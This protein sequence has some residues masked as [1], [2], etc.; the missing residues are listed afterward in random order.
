MLIASC[1]RGVP[2]AGAP[3]PFDRDRVHADYEG[4]DFDRVIR[5]L[6]R[7]RDSGRP[8]GRADSLFMEKH[9]GVVYA[10]NPATRERGRYHF[11]RMLA[12][13]P[14]ADLL[15]M[16]VGDEVDGIFGKVR[17]EF[18]LTGASMGGP[19][20]PSRKSASHPADR[21]PYRARAKARAAAGKPADT[22]QM[23]IR[24]SAGPT[25]GLDLWSLEPVPV[26]APQPD[27]IPASRPAVAAAPLDSAARP[28]WRETGFWVGGGAA[29]AVIGLTLYFAGQGSEESSP[30]ER[31]FRVPARPA[32]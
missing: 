10:A 12:I 30:R 28:A 27:P 20:A 15:D 19:Q 1:F 8:C 18:A 7:F 32:Q 29:V 5:A 31:I 25:P 17:R 2:S 16:F 3:G 4:G 23:A 9:L 11:L 22:R 13:E 26:S 21:S 24:R 14:G 6:E